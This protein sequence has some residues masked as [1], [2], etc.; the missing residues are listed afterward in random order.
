M[1]QTDRVMAESCAYYTSHRI[2][3]ARMEGVVRQRMGQ[4]KQMSEKVCRVD[5]SRGA[6]AGSQ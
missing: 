1:L 2:N 6:M 3:E 4:G 5:E